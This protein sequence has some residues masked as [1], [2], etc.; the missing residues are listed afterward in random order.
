MF[1]S[2]LFRFPVGY[3][4]SLLSF[5]VISHV[6]TENRVFIPS[7]PHWGD[8]G[9]KDDDDDNLKWEDDG[10]SD[11]G[12]SDDGHKTA[13]PTYSPTK[14]PKV[15]TDSPTASPKTSSPTPSPTEDAKTSAPTKSWSDDGHDDVVVDD[16]KGDD[17]GWDGDGHEILKPEPEEDGDG[18]DGTD[19]DDGDEDLSEGYEVICFEN[20]SPVECE[21]D[22]IGTE[23]YYEYRYMVELSSESRRNLEDGSST[24]IANKMEIALLN[25]FAYLLNGDS[26][27]MQALTRIVGPPDDEVASE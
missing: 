19:D 18:D 23:V 24:G 2:I 6:P 4:N 22:P 11:D 9:R 21:G 1:L 20:G 8:D 13:S 12:W 3:C 7:H 5:L 10:H 14:S 26:P 15:K 27:S 25:Q 17:D 16:D